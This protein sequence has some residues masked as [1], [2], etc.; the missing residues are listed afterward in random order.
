M[1]T[2]SCSNI[3][4]VVVLILGVREGMWEGG[5]WLGSDQKCYNLIKVNWYGGAYCDPPHIIINQ[6]MPFKLCLIKNFQK[7]LRESQD[8]LDCQPFGVSADSPSHQSK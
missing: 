2:I 6:H 4:R 5:L 8:T 7:C 3:V 1:F